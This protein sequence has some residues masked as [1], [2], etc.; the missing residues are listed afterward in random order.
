MAEPRGTGIRSQIGLAL[1]RAVGELGVEGELPD[2]ELGRAKV[3]EH[4]DYAS[5]AGL[6]LARALRRPPPQIAETIAKTITVPD[7][8]ATAEADRGYVNFRLTSEWLQRLVTVIASSREAQGR[9]DLERGESVQVE[10]G[11]INPTGP[12]HIGHGRGVVL[13][14]SMCRLLEFTGYQVKREYYVN[15]QNTQAR[16]FG[17]SVWAR[18]HG[19]E[20]PEGGY[21]GEYVTELA[22]MAKR[23]LGDVDSLPRDEA[24]TK[25]RDYAIGVMVERIRASVARLNVRYDEWFLESRLWTEGLPQQAI[26][27]LRES[28][29]LKER[30]GALWFGEALEEEDGLG[31]QVTSKQ[32]QKEED[33][34]VIRSNGEPTYFASDLGYLLS[35]FERRHFNRVVEVWAADHHG[36][37]PRMKSAAAA[38]GIDPLRLVIILHQMV[39]LKEG[40]MSKRAGRFVT[41]D[42]LIDR[43][44][45]DAV[46]YFYLLRSPD[47]PIEFDLELALS[48]SNENPVYY[49]QYAH[50]RLANVEGTARERHAELP[51]RADV[52]LLVQPWELDVA[53][54]LAFWPDA[55][56]DATRLL[57]PHRIPYYVHDLATSVHRFYHAG[58][59]AGEHRVVVDDPE[60]TRARLELCRAARHTLKTALDLIGVAAPDR[61]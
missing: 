28:G 58:N 15:D 8:A 23:E 1:A 47:T 22:E 30:D 33:R 46:R 17:A 3:T 56:D 61:M 40:K 25:V 50:A 37:V 60:L 10:F 13:G 31:E 21:A 54:Q 19:E 14:D 52:S 29:F 26:A 6:K 44:G 18:M 43:V 12:M 51:E 11:S 38:L 55:V 57:E 20:P 59:E 48:Q 7:G 9:G 36:Y 35:R 24:E 41:L 2:L 39:S 4:G 16:R 45:S 42:E 34:V 5:P 53:R 27:R 32:E 49:A